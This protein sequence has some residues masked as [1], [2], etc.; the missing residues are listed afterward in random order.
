MCFSF[1]SFAEGPRCSSL[2]S[3]DEIPYLIT[4]ADLKKAFNKISNEFKGRLKLNPFGEHD[5][6]EPYNAFFLP[7]GGFEEGISWRQLAK[8]L[9]V[10]DAQ[11]ESSWQ[12]PLYLSPMEIAL[13]KGHLFP[14]AYFIRRTSTGQGMNRTMP[15]NFPSYGEK[16]PYVSVRPRAIDVHD[17]G[18]SKKL[19][20]LWSEGLAEKHSG[21]VTLYRAASM[22][23]YQLQAIIQKLYRSDL[24]EIVTEAEVLEI[25]N[26]L[27]QKS[28]EKAYSYGYELRDIILNHKKASKKE[29]LSALTNSLSFL[30]GGLFT[31]DQADSADAF[32][33]ES[34]DVVISYTLPVAMLGNL[35]N[36]NEVYFGIEFDYFEIAFIDEPTNQNAKLFLINSLSGVKY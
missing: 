29:L 3:S 20:E 8:Q 1:V 36:K 33:H 18:G 34:D 26:I 32:R 27:E 30:S 5:E 23:E 22:T 19:F 4:T 28:G 16:L 2:F 25:K 9:N 31:T 11:I 15:Q 7:E 17:T 14:S 21:F 12:R 35:V 10:T 13:Y 24:N 6:S